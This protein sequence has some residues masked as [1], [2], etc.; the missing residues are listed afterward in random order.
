MKWVDE[1]ERD[2]DNETPLPNLGKETR[3]LHVLVDNAA[4]LVDDEITLGSKPP[5]SNLEV[6]TAVSDTSESDEEDDDQVII[7]PHKRIKQGGPYQQ[8]E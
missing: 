6:A 3:D 1:M 7:E 4:C 5:Q 8:G 2:A